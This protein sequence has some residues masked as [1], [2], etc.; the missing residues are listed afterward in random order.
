MPGQIKDIPIQDWV[1]LAVCRT[2]ATGAEALFW[3]DPT[4]AHDANLI[5]LVK[6]YLANHDTTGC[7]I[8]FLKPD[9]ACSLAWDRGSEGL[10]TLNC[11]SNVLRDYL[12]DLFSIHKIDTV[13]KRFESEKMELE[14]E[15]ALEQE[16]RI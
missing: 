12:D 11:T 3:P 15:D 13:F 7:D 6:K 2:K 16:F 4:R 8:Q 1:K 5:Y 9:D 10:D 14:P